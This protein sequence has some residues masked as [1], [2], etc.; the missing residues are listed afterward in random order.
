MKVVIINH[1]AGIPNFFE[2]SL[3]HY[4]FAK[5]IKDKNLDCS[6]ITS[7]KTYQS[8]NKVDK[9]KL[10]I[11]DV[12]YFFIDEPDIN[13][14]NLFSKLIKMF[15]F[16]F[17]LFKYLFFNQKF[18][19]VD[20]V[21]ASSPDLFT[22]F[23]SY[24]FA[25][26]KSSKF[27]F[28]V[29]DIWPL[30]QIELHNFSKYHPMIVIF[31]FIENLLHRKADIV[32]SNLPYYQQYLNDSG[33]KYN[34]YYYIPQVVD[35]EYYDNHYKKIELHSNHQKIFDIYD[36]V[37]IYAGTIGKYYGI[38]NLINAL[39]LCNNSLAIILMGDG[40]FKNEAEKLKKKR[41]LNNLF[42]I[43]SQEKSYLFSLFQKCSFGIVSFPE[44]KLYS[45]GIASLKMLDYLYA[46]L[47]ILMIGP[48]DKYSILSNSKNK[49]SSKFGDINGIA[50]QY[51]N[52]CEI[53]S[54]DKVNIGLEN[55]QLLEKNASILNLKN[56]LN[57]IL[58]I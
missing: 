21:I 5:H 25:R 53:D 35:L 3:R 29:R 20:F 26:K 55:H 10:L 14:K 34:Q 36:N 46:K 58:N 1:F 32:I 47:P 18:N 31:K 12:E 51:K 56:Q 49:H 15:G 19:N 16:S 40:D 33:L 41:N 4:Y 13:S 39:S 23:I 43:N 22:G 42:I 9:S 52:L 30:S 7:S 24:L 6:I 11:N 8:S 27:I 48:F 17:N 28:E 54:E 37:G 44:K 45:Y 57:R 2:S 50:N 38:D